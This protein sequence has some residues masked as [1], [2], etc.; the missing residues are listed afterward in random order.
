MNRLTRSLL[1][2]ALIIMIA[3][4]GCAGNPAAGDGEGDGAAEE[5][6]D[7]AVISQD[8]VDTEVAMKVGEEAVVTFDPAYNWDITTTPSLVVDHVA[9]A[10]LEEGQQARLVAKRAGS[11]VIQATGRALCRQ[12]DPPCTDPT[13]QLT[14]KLRVSE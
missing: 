3:L 2:I 5:A 13:L 10:V 8:M 6:V 11:A 12:D 4:A 9:D 14:V 1:F 7:A